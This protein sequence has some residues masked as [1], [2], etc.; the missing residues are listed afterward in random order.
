MGA[1]V[2]IIIVVIII[3]VIASQSN[4]KQSA[5]DTGSNEPVSTFT[6]L[7]PVEAL[8]EIRN[9]RLS[10][11][12]TDKVI[13]ANGEYCH[14]IDKAYLLHERVMKKFHTQT[15]SVSYPSL[16]SILFDMGQYSIRH[17]QGEAHTQIE[18][19]PATDRFKGL[20]FI[21][22]RRIIFVGK[23]SPFDM[24]YKSLT[25]KTAYSD[26]IEFQFGSKYMSL[27]VPDGATANAVVD[28]VLAR[29]NI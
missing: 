10:R 28:L 11:L 22:N 16:L 2:I 14:Y 1:L 21:T 24:P 17:R 26:G 8:S 3:A 18:E 29:R 7:M 20:L 13:L 15:R 19:I 25:A 5:S 27:L 23:K 6:T 12:T 4:N 9:G